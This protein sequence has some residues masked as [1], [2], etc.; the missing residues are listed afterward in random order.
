VEAS[1]AKLPAGA[2]QVKHQLRRVRG[3]WSRSGGARAL[4]HAAARV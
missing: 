2:T 1:Q 3:G 4:A